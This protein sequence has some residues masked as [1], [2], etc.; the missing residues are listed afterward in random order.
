MDTIIYLFTGTGNSLKIARDSSQGIPNS[1][2]RHIV[3]VLADEK[4]AP[5]IAGKVEIVFP[6]YL[7][8]LRSSLK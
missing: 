8:G 4:S 3:A 6:A 2:P 1:E 5:I 7:E